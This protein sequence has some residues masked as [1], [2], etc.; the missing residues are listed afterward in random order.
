MQ[1]FKSRE[2]VKEQF[3]WKHY[4][5]FLTAKGVEY[6]REYLNLPEDIVP[7]TH[8]SRG[9]D[10]P[11]GGGPPPKRFDE[12]GPPGEGEDYRGGYRGGPSKD[13]KVE[14]DSMGD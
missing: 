12:R 2:L 4:Y 3:A 5:W 11:G 8:K 7:A 10:R 9:R 14:M 13:E 6:L 1:S